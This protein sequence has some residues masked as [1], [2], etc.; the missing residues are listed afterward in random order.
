MTSG[1]V[2]HSLATVARGGPLYPPVRVTLESASRNLLP[3]M[4][5]LTLQH[6]APDHSVAMVVLPD[7][8]DD[9][10]QLSD[11]LEAMLRTLVPP[12]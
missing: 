12:T 11:S 6:G 5:R 9:P 7:L 8:L 2:R 4:V 3:D 1:V 10:H